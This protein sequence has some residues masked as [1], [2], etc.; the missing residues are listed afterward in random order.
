M[1]FYSPEE[2]GDFV[3]AVMISLAPYVSKGTMITFEL[4]SRKDVRSKVTFSH[5]Q[6]YS[7]EEAR[8]CEIEHEKRQQ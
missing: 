3:N 1:S 8:Q 2:C 7:E 4:V 6:I 5:P